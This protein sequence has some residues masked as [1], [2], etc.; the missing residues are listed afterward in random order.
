MLTNLGETTCEGVWGVKGVEG[1]YPG[2]WL[3]T[4]EVGLAKVPIPGVAGE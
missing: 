4:G 3:L 1:M 2:V